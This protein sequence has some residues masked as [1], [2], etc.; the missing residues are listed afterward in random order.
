MPGPSESFAIREFAGSEP[1]TMNGRF[2]HWLIFI[3]F[4][5]LL[6][7]SAFHASE[8][9][10]SNGL[11]TCCLVLPLLIVFLSEINMPFEAFSFQLKIAARSKSWR[12]GLRQS[13]YATDKLMSMD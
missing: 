2:V 13:R 4:P 10:N 9:T 11:P 8:P 5:A 1:D 3:P 6:P 7:E 12:S